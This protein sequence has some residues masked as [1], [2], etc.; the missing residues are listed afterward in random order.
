M[1]IC[2]VLDGKIITSP[3]KGTIL[4]GITRRSILAL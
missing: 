2:F 1:N 3:L 4:D